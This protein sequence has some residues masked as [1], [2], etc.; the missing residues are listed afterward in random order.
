MSHEFDLVRASFA[1][2]WPG[3]LL[4]IVKPIAESAWRTSWFRIAIKGVA[5]DALR[6][7]QTSIRTVATVI[8]VAAALQ[9]VLMWMMPLVI[10]PR[11]PFYVFVT[12]A[13]LAAVAAC[14]P[15]GIAAAWPES[16]FARRLRR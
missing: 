13:A 5:A 8:V 2:S 11:M 7:V 3:R 16:W 4:A 15:D 14:R 1:A 10:R 9:P 12:I 6:T